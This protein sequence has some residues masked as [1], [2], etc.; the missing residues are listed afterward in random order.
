[1]VRARIRLTSGGCEHH[2]P[3]DG[4]VDLPVA[5]SFRGFDITR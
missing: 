2:D 3:T 4:I 5:V 1:M